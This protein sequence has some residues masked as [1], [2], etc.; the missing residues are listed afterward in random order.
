MFITPD[1]EYGFKSGRTKVR[2]FL[3]FSSEFL[4]YAIFDIFRI[5]LF[6]SR[7]L[8]I[9][10][11]RSS[12]ILIFYRHGRFIYQKLQTNIERFGN[13]SHNLNRMYQPNM[14]FLKKIFPE[15]SKGK[16]KEDKLF[17][18]EFF[19]FKLAWLK[20]FYTS[21]I[22]TICK[23]YA[24]FKRN[25]KVRD[26]GPFYLIDYQCPFPDFCRTIF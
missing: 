26:C 24:N 20:F 6:I 17:E 11:S 15:R 12:I 19:W 25:K 8:A 13:L 21:G 23:S 22:V 14:I 4:I 1:G 5:I 3:S 18:K 2:L 7:G 16:R 9:Y 10:S